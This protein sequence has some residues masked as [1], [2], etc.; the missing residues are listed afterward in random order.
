MQTVPR[1][2]E[3]PCPQPLPSRPHIG[4][5]SAPPTQCLGGT[6]GGLGGGAGWEPDSQ[7]FLLQQVPT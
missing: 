7:N 2:D 5:V 6:P 3:A 1:Q 4:G